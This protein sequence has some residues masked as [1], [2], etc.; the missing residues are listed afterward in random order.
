[1]FIVGYLCTLSVGHLLLL[2]LFRI[3]LLFSEIDQ[4]PRK[5]SIFQNGGRGPQNPVSH[6][7][8]GG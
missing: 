8:K 1:M 6:R 2:L 7:V 3:T 5:I 4:F